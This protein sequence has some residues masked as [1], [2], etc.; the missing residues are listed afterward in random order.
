VARLL[1][2]GNKAYEAGDFSK[3]EA[4]WAKIRACGRGSADWPKAV[5]NLGLLENRRKNFRQAIAY[6]DEVIQSHPNDKEPGGNIMETNRNYSHR[7]ALA[8]SECY[9]AMGAYRMALRYARL[10]K[11][12]YPFYSW[13]G[14]CLQSENLAVNKRIAYLT[15][16]ASRVH[17]WAG[18]LLIGFLAF[19]KV[20]G[21]RNKRPP[22]D[23]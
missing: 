9:E 19:R 3:A 14:T 20:K 7:S 13:C 11:T 10:A 2:E 6:F 15:A 8:I 17:I 18:A 23:C 22:E 4:R 1:E 16:R 21:T 12:T 5:F